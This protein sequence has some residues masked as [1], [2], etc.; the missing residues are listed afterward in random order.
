MLCLLWLAIRLLDSWE[1]KIVFLWC[2]PRVK[3]MTQDQTMLLWQWRLPMA[4]WRPSSQRYICCLLNC[5]HWLI[6]KIQSSPILFAHHH[7]LSIR[8]CADW[9]S[10][11]AGT[12]WVSHQCNCQFIFSLNLGLVLLSLSQS[13]DWLWKCKAHN[14]PTNRHKKQ[15]G[16]VYMCNIPTQLLISPRVSFSLSFISCLRWWFL[17]SNSS[18]KPNETTNTHNKTRGEER[19]YSIFVSLFYWPYWIEHKDCA[20]AAIIWSRSISDAIVVVGS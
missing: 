7:P 6:D 5:T 15:C 20:N 16:T 9:L 4:T 19:V 3:M 18:N 8:L 12:L 1:F 17:N 14:P 11:A 13:L 2:R 10:A